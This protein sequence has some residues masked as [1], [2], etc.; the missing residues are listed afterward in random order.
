MTD[1][2]QNTTALSDT[3]K[4]L[5]H[6]SFASNSNWPYDWSENPSYTPTDA[7]FQTA[8]NLWFDNQAEANATYGHISDW[9]TSAITN[10]T[11]A[12]LNRTSFNENIGNWDVSNV[13]SFNSMFEAVSAFNQ[14]INGWNT[15]SATSFNSMFKGAS[16]FNQNIGMFH[17]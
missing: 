8:V 5:I 11:D 17:Q 16:S 7:N 15:E 9:N 13:T 12:F 4:G 14:D 6:Q 2:F 10:M 3:N 1:M